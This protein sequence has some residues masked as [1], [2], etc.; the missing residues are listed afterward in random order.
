MIG[1]VADL[2]SKSW[3]S[4]H[5][6][7]LAVCVL[8][9]G[10]SAGQDPNRPP[11]YPVRGTVTL[12]GKPVEGAVVTFQP[13]E[14]KGSAVGSTDANGVYTLSTFNPSDGALAGQ[15]KVS[16]AKYEGGVSPTSSS[17]NAP[18]QLGP[19]GLPDDYAPPALTG[20]VSRPTGPKNLLPAKYANPDSSALRAT[21]DTGKNEINFDMK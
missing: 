5:V 20:N 12:N 15:Y 2:I 13:M 18:G 10:C 14:G 16:I 21:V 11:T 3:H 9:L 19:P 7:L 4:A 1:C 6:P 8:A 17:T